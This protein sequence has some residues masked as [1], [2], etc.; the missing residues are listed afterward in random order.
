MRQISAPDFADNTIYTT[1]YTEFLGCS[2]LPDE[3]QC[4]ESYSPDC[5]NM[6]ADVAGF[7][8]KRPGWRTLHN[9]DAYIF[10]IH[11]YQAGEQKLCLVHAGTKLYA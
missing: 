6:I 1:A 2:F 4:G 7:P 9:F 10:G 5:R 3:T 8:E 11:V